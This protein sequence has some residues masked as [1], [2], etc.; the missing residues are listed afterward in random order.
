MVLFMDFPPL[1][2]LSGFDEGWNAGAEMR[3]SIH[4]ELRN[5]P[6]HLSERSANHVTRRGINMQMG[7][8]SRSRAW[9]C[10]KGQQH[11]DMT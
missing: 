6:S 3:V 2:S 9:A 4:T 1:L 8:D 11:Q 5:R 7:G 10:L